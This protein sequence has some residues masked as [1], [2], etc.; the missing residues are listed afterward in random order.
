MFALLSADEAAKA[1]EHAPAAQEQAVHHAPI[2]VKLVNHYFGEWAHH[3]RDEV[4]VPG[5][6]ESARQVRHHAGSSV[7]RLHA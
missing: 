7:W 1:A 3:L 4:H 6:E 5:V 2:L